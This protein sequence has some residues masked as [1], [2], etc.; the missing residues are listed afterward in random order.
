M[1]NHAIALHKKEYAITGSDDE[2]SEPSG[3]KQARYGF[4]PKK[5]DGILE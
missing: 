4:F 5:T 1:H 2:I 3:S